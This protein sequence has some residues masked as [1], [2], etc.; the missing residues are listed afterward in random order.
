MLGSN[1]F[2]YDASS[3]R[4]WLWIVC[5][6]FIWYVFS[7][8]THSLSPTLNYPFCLSLPSSESY[9]SS[10]FIL[11]FEIINRSMFVNRSSGT[12][13][14]DSRSSTM[15]YLHRLCF[16]CLCN[17]LPCWKWFHGAPPWTPLHGPYSCFGSIDHWCNAIGS[18]YDTHS[19]GDGR[20]SSI[21]K[22]RNRD[23]VNWWKVLRT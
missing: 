14:V 9:P 5:S 22:R 6:Y 11:I 13:I 3:T 18:F 7:L 10:Y 19:L 20:S 8:F 1:W 17:V 23:A 16:L 15:G 2:L 4:I 12:S 21:W